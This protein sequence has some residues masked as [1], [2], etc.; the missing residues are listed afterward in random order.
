MHAIAILPV[1]LLLAGCYLSQEQK[2][3]W[4]KDND[5]MILRNDDEEKDNL[6]P[7]K[8]GAMEGALEVALDVAL[9]SL[10]LL[11]SSRSPYL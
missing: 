1:T 5:I 8:E 6:D 11:T 7:A 4:F 3:P 10:L 9:D 2:M